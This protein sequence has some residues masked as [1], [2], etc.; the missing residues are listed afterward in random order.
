[1]RKREPEPLN[2]DTS[3]AQSELSN[4]DSSVVKPELPAVDS[5]ESLSSQLDVLLF[6]PLVDSSSPSRIAPSVAVPV[7]AQTSKDIYSPA[8]E[9]QLVVTGS[10]ESQP[11]VDNRLPQ[12]PKPLVFTQA[13]ESDQLY[14]G[15]L[16]SKQIIFSS[17]PAPVDY[18]TKRPSIHFELVEE[19][20]QATR[21]QTNWNSIPNRP[22]QDLF[23]KLENSWGKIREVGLLSHQS[24]YFFT[25]SKGQHHEV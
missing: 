15:H 7:S 5:S 12:L 11:L 25:L 6:Q 13:Q 17:S 4:A 19:E 9:Q 14:A 22:A 16:Q 21:G 8:P 18:A 10:S 3:V 2:V 23:T 20:S 1:L 24:I